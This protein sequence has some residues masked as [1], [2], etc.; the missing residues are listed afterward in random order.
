M[1]DAG[2]YISKKYT[3]LT[4]R[5]VSGKFGALTNVNLPANFTDKLAYDSSHAY[6]NLTLNMTSP[7]PPPTAFTLP[8]A[9]NGNQFNVANALT[10]YFNR[11]GGIPTAFGTLSS[12]GLTQASGEAA[13]GIQQPTF[14]AMD[15]FIGTLLGEAGAGLAGA[16]GFANPGAPLFYDDPTLPTHKSGALAALTPQ[17]AFAPAWSVWA[18]TYGGAGST[19][20]NGGLGTNTTTSQTYGVMAGA[21]YRLA[22]D[23]V[24]GFGM[25]GGGTSFGIANSLGGGS[26]GLFQAGFYGIHN[27]GTAYVSGAAAY[28]WQE[29]TTNRSVTVTG[30]GNLQA[31]FDANTIEARAEAG[32]R[33]ATPYV[34]VT[35][36]GALQVTSLFLPSYGESANSG[37]S[38]FALNYASQTVTDTRTELGA[39]FDKSFDMSNALLTLGG[40]L[41]WAHDFEPT[42]AANATFQSLPGASFTVNGATPS[43]NSALVTAGAQ[44]KW[45]NGFAIEANFEGDFSSNTKS[46]GGRGTLRYSW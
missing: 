24:L 18:G 28:G 38:T 33:Y 40:R 39:R 3:I 6:L 29:V 25:A 17:P 32:D 36:Y 30:G 14:H 21:D 41:A 45:A 26:S 4:A 5:S 42:A 20:G 16:R 2:G 12:T 22:P 44:V 37:A 19:A 15:L 31:K 43:P 9:L 23:T 27:F 1:F 10:Q 7:V 13:T 8:V 34:G 11:T 46:Y 35:P